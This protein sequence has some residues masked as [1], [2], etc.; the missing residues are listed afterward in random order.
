MTETTRQDMFS[1]ILRHQLVRIGRPNARL[2]IAHDFTV[3]L[4]DDD[5]RWQGPGPLAFGALVT[6]DD[7]DGAGPDLW[8][9]LA[10]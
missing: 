3:T 5:G 4:V 7:G 6:Y 1:D 10:A 2:T 9:R 8:T